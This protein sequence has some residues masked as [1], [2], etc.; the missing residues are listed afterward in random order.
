M[1][2]GCCSRRFI[3]VLLSRVLL[4]E[5]LR[6]S[7]PSYCSEL[8]TVNTASCSVFFSEVSPQGCQLLFLNPVPPASQC[9]DTCRMYLIP[10]RNG[11]LHFL[12]GTLLARGFPLERDRGTGGKDAEPPP[13]HTQTHTHTHTHTHWPPSPSAT[14]VVIKVIFGN[15]DV[16]VCN[17]HKHNTVAAC[18]RWLEHLWCGPRTRS[19]VSALTL[20][21]SVL[22]PLQCASILPSIRVHKDTIRKIA[23]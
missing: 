8:L 16:L 3:A 18:G 5:G 4:P 23:Q 15:P 1:R 13:P 20:P 12:P 11:P 19:I 22:P 14:A 6:R 17:F 7:G 21:E 2:P 10:P 9:S